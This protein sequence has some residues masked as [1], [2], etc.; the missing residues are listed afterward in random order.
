MV[1]GLASC[2]QEDDP[3]YRVPDAE[4]FTINTPAFQNVVI[5]T[6]GNMEDASTFNL[7]CSQPDYGYS[8]ICE[9]YAIASLSPD[10][11]LDDVTTEDGVTPKAVA[12]ENRTPAKAEMTMK[13]Y[14]LAVA[15]CK[16]YGIKDEADYEAKAPKGP[17]KVYFKAV[18]SIPGVDGSKVTTH[19]SV[20]Y[21]SVLISYA[22]PKPDWIYIVGNIGSPDGQFKMFD[23]TNAWL[24]PAMANVDEYNAHYQLVEPVIGS[25]CYAGQFLYYPKPEAA[26]SPTPTNPVDNYGQFRFFTTLNGWSDKTVQVASAEGDFY[27]ED[28]T[29]AFVNGLY[30]D[31]TAVF[32]QGNWGWF[33]EDPM[34]V[35]LVVNV[36]TMKVWFQQ[37]FYEVTL[38]A[39]SKGNWT[40]QFSNPSN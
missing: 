35:T 28:L 1:M 38:L 10:F 27:C 40:P 30:G 15:M 37:G 11:T 18:C 22:V 6:T 31:K 20:A 8:A 4:T 39:D 26:Q 2:S 33:T 19:N 17:V 7:Y 24:T 14:D 29:N 9:Y 36:K 3:K 21:N 13:L 34:P 16:L 5:E 12:L 23:D 32:G 25:K